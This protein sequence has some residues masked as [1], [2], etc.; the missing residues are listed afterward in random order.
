MRR[1]VSTLLPTRLS[2]ERNTLPRK[3]AASRASS[4]PHS[5]AGDLVRGW[6]PNTSM[7]S[8]NSQLKG[9]PRLHCTDREWYAFTSSRS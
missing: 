7:M 8:Q 3:P 4:S 2:S 1:R 9:H 6:R 5:C